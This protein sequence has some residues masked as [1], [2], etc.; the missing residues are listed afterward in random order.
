MF[1]LFS[2]DRLTFPSRRR[3]RPSLEALEGKQLLSLGPQIVG[4][5]NTKTINAQYG[6]DNATNAGGDSVVVWTDTWSPTDTDIRAQRYNSF[7]AKVGP[8]IIVA[9]SS[10]REYD[11]SVAIDGQGR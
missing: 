8:E 3:R 10:A 2:H 7:G 6:S 5:V 1:P 9:F 11:P 4:T